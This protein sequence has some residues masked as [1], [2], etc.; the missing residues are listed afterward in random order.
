M[1]KVYL[2]ILVVF[3]AFLTGFSQDPLISESCGVEFVEYSENE[4]SGVNEGDEVENLNNVWLP[5]ELVSCQAC[6]LW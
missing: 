2:T 1:K 6:N 4:Q 3:I 5:D